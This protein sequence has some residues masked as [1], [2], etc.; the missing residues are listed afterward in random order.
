MSRN[1]YTYGTTLYTQLVGIAIGTNC[2][3]L[4]DDL[5]LFCYDKKGFIV[6]LSEDK[7]ADV[8]ET[9]NS[10]PTYLDEPLNIDNA[11]FDGTVNRI[12]PSEPQL[13]KANSS[14]PRP[15][16]GFTFI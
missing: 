11:Y 1:M 16:F 3:P 5:F 10:T 4:V 8:I 7:K 9:V 2:A 14:D 13:N 15:C 6:S 12:C